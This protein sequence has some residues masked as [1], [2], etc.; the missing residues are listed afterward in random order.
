MK[1][2]GQTRVTE[3]CLPHYY[4]HSQTQ[5]SKPETTAWHIT[6]HNGLKEESN[7]G[8]KERN[9]GAGRGRGEG[10][11]RRKREE[12]GGRGENWKEGKLIPVIFNSVLP[13]GN[14]GMQRLFKAFLHPQTP[15]LHS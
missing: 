8:E 1:L 10:G 7:E 2:L 6:Q 3:F 15:T 9:E 4:T 12:G 11:R 13:L 5:M 14:T